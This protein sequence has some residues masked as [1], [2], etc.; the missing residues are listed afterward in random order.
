MKKVL[1]AVDLD[2][3][4]CDTQTEVVNRLRQILYGLAQFDD[5]YDVYRRY[6]TN[7]Q[8]GT[9]STMLY[10]EH[11]RKLINP[12]IIREGSYVNTVKPTALLTNGGLRNLVENLRMILGDRFTSVVA[13]HRNH[14]ASV[15]TN[16][17]TWLVN[18]GARDLFDDLHFIHGGQYANKIAYLKEHYPDHEIVLLDDNP[19]GDLQSVHE[20]NPC[21]MV[22]EEL[23]HYD[24]YQ[25]QRK[26]RSIEALEMHLYQL[27]QTGQPEHETQHR[28]V[29]LES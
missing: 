20:Y 17:D 16:T 14:E 13:T 24:A 7:L 21:V 10:P 5:L 15:Q 2:D 9:Q 4:L 29:D 6:H 12:L 1:L 26:F 19:F 25:H 8:T 28:A 23:C 11:L 27:S 22:Y 18:H 3:T